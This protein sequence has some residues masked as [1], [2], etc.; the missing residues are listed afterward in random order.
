MLYNYTDAHDGVSGCLSAR[1]KQKMSASDVTQFFS[2]GTVLCKK[3]YFSF[4]KMAAYEQKT[5][6]T[7]MVIFLRKCNFYPK[8]SLWVKSTKSK[9]NPKRRN[10]NHGHLLPK[11]AFTYVL[12]FL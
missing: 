8:M 7:K 6:Y 12:T 5:F 2:L 1:Q 4:E 3:K 10:R 11:V 9:K